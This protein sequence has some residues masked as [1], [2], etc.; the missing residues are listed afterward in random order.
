MRSYALRNGHRVL[1]RKAEGDRTEFETRN[2][3][4]ETI[5]TVI[6]P[7]EETLELLR[8]MGA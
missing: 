1:T 7:R 3:Q 2:A 6:L 4:G 5:S 8:A